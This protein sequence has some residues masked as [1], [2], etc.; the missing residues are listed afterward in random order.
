MERKGG[1]RAGEGGLIGRSPHVSLPS[2]TLPYINRLSN[3]RSSLIASLYFLVI[4]MLFYNP[5]YD[6]NLPVLFILFFFFGEED[7][8]N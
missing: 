6:T 1:Q 8:D 2:L 4:T 5:P 7:S 3:K